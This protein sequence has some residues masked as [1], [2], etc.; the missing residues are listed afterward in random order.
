VDAAEGAGVVKLEANVG[1]GREPRSDSWR[2]RL[3]D[4]VRR[5]DESALGEIW[6]RLMAIDFIDRAVL[7]AGIMVV[8]L[9]PALI[10]LDG[11]H[12]RSTVDSISR[13]MGLNE[14]ASNAVSGLFTRPEHRGVLTVSA[15]VVVVFGLLGTAEAIQKLYE[16][17]FEVEERRARKTWRRATWALATIAGTT[18]LRVATEHL[19]SLP[20][21]QVLAFG[22]SFAVLAAYFWWS[23]HFLLGG[24]IAWN[25]LV[26][27]AVATSLFW[28]GLGL[29]SSFYFSAAVIKNEQLY[30]PIGV[31]FVLMTWLLAVGVVLMLGPVVGTAW[32]HSRQRRREAARIRAS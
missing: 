12:G 18:G 32:R 29:F 15:L 5:F 10:A 30:G 27:P 8:W 26:A 6:H 25:E 21:G 2:G 14:E 16:L 4:A 19:S 11:I 20:G 28:L 9:I 17:V 1:T 24:L 31:V 7:L 23:M 13:R 3:D 22:F